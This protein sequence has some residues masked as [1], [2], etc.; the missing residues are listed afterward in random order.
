MQNVSDNFLAKWAAEDF[1]TKKIELVLQNKSLANRF[2]TVASADTENASYPASKTNDGKNSHID[3]YWQNTGIS[4]TQTSKADW[5]A[6]TYDDT[7]GDPA[8]IEQPTSGD[9]V[10]RYPIPQRTNLV[11]FWQLDETSGTNC[12]DQTSNNLDG[13]ANDASTVNSAGKINWCRYHSGNTHRITLPN[14]S[15]LKPQSSFTIA[16]WLKPLSNIWTNGHIFGNYAGNYNGYG[17]TFDSNN[18]GKLCLR[19]GGGGTTLS[20]YFS[21]SVVSINTWHFIAVTFNGTG[22]PVY[23][24]IDGSY[25][26]AGNATNNVAY[27]NISYTYIGNN[28]NW[29]PGFIGYVDEVLFYNTALNKTDLDTLYAN[30]SPTRYKTSGTHTSQIIDLGATPIYTGTFTITKTEP[31]GNHYIT[32]EERHGNTATPD[33]SWS[34]YASISNNGTLPAG[35]RYFQIRTT[36][37]G[38]GTNTPTLHDYTLVW[39]INQ[40]G[41][42]HTFAT[43]W[44]INE[45]CFDS[46][47][48]NNYISEFKLQYWDGS[49]YQDITPTKC[50]GLNKNNN[51][52][53][54]IFP[55]ATT[56]SLIEEFTTGGLAMYLKIGSGTNEKLS[57]GFKI[58]NFCNLSSIKLSLRR[59]DAISGNIWVEVWDGVTW[60]PN[61]TKL[62]SSNNVEGGTLGTDFSWIEFTFA[63]GCLLLANKQ[64]Y[65]KIR[66]D[67]AIQSLIQV[68]YASGNLYTDGSMA[69]QSISGD[70]DGGTWTDNYSDYD[71]MFQIY[72]YTEDWTQKTMITNAT[73]NYIQFDEVSTSRIRLVINN[74]SDGS[75]CRVAE[76]K[77]YRVVD[78]S[79]DY[80]SGSPS[81][82]M[83][84]TKREFQGANFQL[85]LLNDKKKYSPHYSPTAEEIA[86]GYFNNEL[87][88]NIRVRFWAG[89][90][91]ENVQIIEGIVDSI[92]VNPS[93]SPP[94]VVF[95]C[96]DEF[97]LLNRKLSIQDNEVSTKSIE[98]CIEYVCN[99]CNISS[100]K[101][102]LTTSNITLDYFITSDENGLDL[103]R[104]LVEASGNATILCNE[105]GQL[106]YKF[107]TN[108]RNWVQTTY[109]DFV[110]GSNSQTNITDE[111]GNIILDIQ[112]GNIPNNNFETGNLNYW[113]QSGSNNGFA[114]STDTP[115]EGSYC[116]RSIRYVGD[117]DSFADCNFRYYIIDADTGNTLAVGDNDTSASWSMCSLNLSPYR[118][119]KIKIR[120]LS[121][122]SYYTY[123]TMTLA[124]GTYIL[125]FDG[126]GTGTIVYLKGSSS[127]SVGEYAW[128]QTDPF[129]CSGTTTFTFRAKVKGGQI[130]T[131]AG[132]ATG[133]YCYRYYFD[134]FLNGK[135]T[136][137]SSG[138]Y[139]SQPHDMGKDFSSWGLLDA[140]VSFS[141][142]ETITFETQSS[143]DGTNWYGQGG[144]NTWD[145][146]VNITS[147]SSRIYGTINSPTSPGG[148]T[149][150]YVRW[151]VTLTT[152]PPY[153]TT[154]RVL[155]VV[156]N[157]NVGGASALPT[158]PAS[159]FGYEGA[160]EGSGLLKDI[161]EEGLS[162]CAGG[163]SQIYSKVV[164]KANPYYLSTSRDVICD[165]GTPSWASGD[166]ITYYADLEYP[167]KLGTSESDY[168]YCHII[169][170]TGN[171]RYISGT[172]QKFA[173]DT[174]IANLTVYFTVHNTKPTIRIVSTGSHT[175]SSFK[176]Y[177]YYYQ[178]IGAI[179]AQALAPDYNKFV[180]EFVGTG[181]SI[182]EID[183]P[184][185]Y[186]LTIANN[187]ATGLISKYGKL[188]P[189]VSGVRVA[190]SP[191]IQ[192][193]D[194]VKLIELNT[195]INRNFY[196]IGITHQLGIGN[197]RGT[198]TIELEEI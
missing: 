1:G 75:Y 143:S 43:T 134:Y 3:G 140:I 62:I 72:G 187:I 80:L 91:N 178:N 9:V 170:A 51:P 60:Y 37:T 85:V 88:P 174:L 105:Q 48:G 147:T 50:W 193:Y 79:S 89:F 66:A 177:A 65:I 157:W 49:A 184:Y 139:T 114:V 151:R 137:Y 145:A 52:T 71:M 61:G 185:I 82:R 29:N 130:Y 69:R 19:V 131:V 186:S 156:I 198:T 153:E 149:A 142:N 86:E 73:L 27:N 22:N 167:G 118:N 164:V 55:F 138:I 180:E 18:T 111:T 191:H 192:L 166:D 128:I 196:V 125:Y 109:A 38:N 101:L 165:L 44:R 190:F 57:Q 197:N 171:C 103:V 28:P 25:E 104:N 46:Y 21:T 36:F 173:A 102:N 92:K 146:L 2:G 195:G 12:N 169:T 10:L 54:V 168:M 87:R 194:L 95:D 78:V 161:S 133:R 150:R 121:F 117:F 45:V 64:Y 181:D 136:Y 115:Y 20:D 155:E 76:M 126:G 30:G 14:N 94:R 83:E 116:A 24:Y 108:K 159:T 56:P 189:Y 33:A 183:N 68:Q 141:G 120:F 162:D 16:L 53:P 160:S 132:E 39:P 81:R 99:K 122:R 58:S 182:L 70:V 163:E 35:Y 96:R 127:S 158:T 34:S 42:L 84:P 59:T 17:F 176:I 188:R 74:T 113:S 106:E 135:R 26:N 98:N 32:Q 90:D 15:L 4:K 100:S 40:G 123:P 119:R 175:V 8:Q 6:G 11:G 154:P 107:L 97:K 31:D 7:E 172:N 144:I 67:Y 124:D 63:S 179:E 112:G 41:L 129:Y 5:D 110:N 47:T 148:S 77:C 23:F 93:A 152:P 13:T